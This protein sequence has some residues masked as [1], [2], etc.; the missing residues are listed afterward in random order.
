MVRT[1]AKVTWAGRQQQAH[2]AEIKAPAKARVQAVPRPANR[3]V[4]VPKAQCRWK[5]WQALVNMF[6]PN[7]ASSRLPISRG[8]GEQ[9]SGMVSRKFVHPATNLVEKAAGGRGRERCR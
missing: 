1:E 4:A 9:Q 7:H 5:A 3:L 8:N 2:R 6:T